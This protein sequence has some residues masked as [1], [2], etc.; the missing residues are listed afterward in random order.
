MRVPVLTDVVAALA[1]I[2]AQVDG[3]NRRLDVLNGTV[4]AHEKSI[5]FL[6]YDKARRDGQS[7]QNKTILHVMEPFLKAAALLLAG[8]V[9][10]NADKVAGVLGHVL[11]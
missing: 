11:K 8:A 2:E 4:A 6:D 10:G 1:R 3:I 5:R 7:A 9:L